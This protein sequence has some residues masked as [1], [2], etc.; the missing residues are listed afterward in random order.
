SRSSASMSLSPPC[1]SGA[2]STSSTNSQTCPIGASI[3]AVELPEMVAMPR[4]LAQMP[5]VAVVGHVEWVD[6]IPVERMPRQGEVVHAQDAFARAAGGGGVV[7]A[8][9]ADLG[10]E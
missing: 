8:V 3:S 4:T 5:R 6:F 1:Q 7:A 10:A 2:F 9:L